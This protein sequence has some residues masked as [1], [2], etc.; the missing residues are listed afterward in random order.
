VELLEYF[1]EKE[2]KKKKMFVK[3]IYEELNDDIK[4]DFIEKNHNFRFIYFVEGQGIIGA[5]TIDELLELFVDGISSNAS[6]YL[7]KK[8]LL[9]YEWKKTLQETYV[10]LYKE[11]TGGSLP[12]SATQNNAILNTL[13]NPEYIYGDAKWNEDIPLFVVLSDYEPVTDVKVPKGDNVYI[14]NPM[15]TNQMLEFWTA[16]GVAELFDKQETD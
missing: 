4:N 11:K 14:L 3:K 5:D 8:I 12:K 2:R 13:L 16:F 9:C 1:S 15:D 6:D 10:N 7:N